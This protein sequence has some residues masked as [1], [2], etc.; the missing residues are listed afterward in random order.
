M[1]LTTIGDVLMAQHLSIESMLR[2]VDSAATRLERG[3]A[4]PP[5]LFVEAANFF[6]VYVQACHQAREEERLFQALELHGVAV[7]GGPIGAMRQE[8][9]RARAYIQ[10]IHGLGLEYAAGTLQDPRPLIDAAHGYAALLRRHELEEDR[11]LFRLAEELLSPAE[12]RE[13]CEVCGQI[14]REGAG[15]GY[16]ERLGALL[17]ELEQATAQ[18]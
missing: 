4:A 17:D 3:L 15:V 10:T 5:T 12:Q 11:V 7:E 13:L 6:D 1:D 9:E 18:P 14:E 16:H 2:I 8:H